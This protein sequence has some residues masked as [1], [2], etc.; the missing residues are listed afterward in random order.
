MV[1]I[2]YFTENREGK[3]NTRD[4]HVYSHSHNTQP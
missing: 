1:D 2:Y 4:I 3:I